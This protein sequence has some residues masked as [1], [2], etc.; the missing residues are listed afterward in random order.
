MNDQDV[1]FVE[2]STS[3]EYSEDWWFRLSI[4]IDW[5]KKKEIIGEWEYILYLL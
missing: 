2:Y 3:W 5:R 1:Y 4:Y